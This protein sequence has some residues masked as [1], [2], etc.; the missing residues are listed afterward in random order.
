MFC[1]CTVYVFTEISFPKTSELNKK[2]LDPLVLLFNFFIPRLSDI[3]S[4]IT[5][6]QL[7]TIEFNIIK[8]KY[9]L[10]VLFRKLI[11]YWIQPKLLV[12]DSQSIPCKFIQEYYKNEGFWEA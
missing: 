11:I 8:S 2:L 6:W 9:F 5:H 12:L 10:M 4:Y 7:G 1:E 3:D